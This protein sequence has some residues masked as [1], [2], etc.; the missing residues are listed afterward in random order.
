MN[1]LPKETEE[2]LAGYA[3][4]L[5]T[6]AMADDAG[7]A[8][9]TVA[10]ATLREAIAAA[11]DN[12]RREGREE[13]AAELDAFAHQSQEAIPRIVAAAAARSKVSQTVAEYG[14]FMI[15][16][17]AEIVRRTGG[18]AADERGGP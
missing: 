14:V 3:R 18:D 17:C 6:F 10:R 12:A 4:E 9:V 5:V 15:R 2:A 1:A 16:R 8:A 13:C 7:D 11:I